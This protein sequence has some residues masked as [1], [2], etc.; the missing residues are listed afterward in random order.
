MD[1][2]KTL[3]G[4]IDELYAGALDQ[5]RLT[6][7]VGQVARLA[8]A[9]GGLMYVM[10]EHEHH[11]IH[12]AMSNFEF[13]APTQADGP[14]AKMVASY[15]RR[16]PLGSAVHVHSLWRMEDM[17]KTQFYH[18]VLKKQDVMYGA[19]CLFLRTPRLHGILTLNRSNR[20]GPF[21]ERKFRILQVLAP[22]FRRATQ[23]AMEL[24]AAARGRE[25]FISAMDN[26]TAGIILADRKGKPLHLNRAAEQIVASHDG[27]WIEHGRLAA[28]LQDENRRLER[29]MAQACDAGYCDAF[30]RGGVC[31]VSRPSGLSPWLVLVAPCNDLQARALVP[32]LPTCMILVRDP[33]HRTRNTA[34]QL[35]QLFMLTHQEAKIAIAVAEGHGL[36]KV[37]D[38]LGLSSL[39]VRN[40]LQRVFAKTGA[41]RQAEL[42]SL[43]AALSA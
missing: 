41:S 6:S 1:I 34:G 15:H 40:H 25:T 22:H 5:T 37:A 32:A 28:A 38:K 9:S 8:S 13:D 3:L 26:L 43:I 11:V 36:S 27:L 4:V 30:Q 12:G 2:N 24:N 16:I 7:S 31:Q 29:S 20:S 35:R 14:H 10:D 39:T 17:L 21:D 18:D 23:L 33:A 19:A 42:V